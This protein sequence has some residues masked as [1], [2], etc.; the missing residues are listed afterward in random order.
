MKQTLLRSV[1]TVALGIAIP[2][3]VV[4]AADKRGESTIVEDAG[5]CTE[6]GC[7]SGQEKCATGT[8]TTAGGTVLNYTCWTTVRGEE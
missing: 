1:L 4:L 5:L 3:S 6:L 7:R 2:V 8:L